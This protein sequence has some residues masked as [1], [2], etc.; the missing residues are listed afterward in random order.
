MKRFIPIILVLSI[1]LSSCGAIADL[2]TPAETATPTISV[3]EI[4]ETADAMVYDMLT[5]TAV[6]MP[7]NTPLPPTETPLPPTPTATFTLVPTVV[8]DIT[9]TVEGAET[10][11]TPTTA[12]VVVPTNTQTTSS[13]AFPCQDK[14]LTSWDVPSVNMQVT[15]TVKDTT[16]N[17][18]L[19]IVTEY[20]AGYISIPAG[21]SASVPY[22]LYTATAWVTGETGGKSFNDT[23]F[24]EVKSSDGLKIVIENGRVYLRAGCWPGC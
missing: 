7:T 23:I 11:A 8:Q 1:L 16:A 10:A 22:G 5:Q 17:V 13:S 3:E 15:N 24:F 18:F 14:P 12:A 21:S 19:C 2:G 20:D 4:R 6:A 9:P